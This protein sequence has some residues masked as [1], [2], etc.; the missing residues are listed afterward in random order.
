MT[1]VNGMPVCMNSSLAL[2]SPF[3]ILF[4]PFG[5]V[6]VVVGF[7]VVVGIGLVVGTLKENKR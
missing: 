7:G 3:W 4:L 2:Q 6:G 5:L 1:R